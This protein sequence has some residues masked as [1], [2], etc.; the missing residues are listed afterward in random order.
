MIADNAI[1]GWFQG[2]TELGPRALGNRSILADPRRADN[3]DR[4]NARI[5]F[6]EEFR[7]FAP[8]VLAERAHEYFEGLGD[9]PFML[10]I[11]GVRPE[12]RSEIPAVVHVDGTARPQTVG[13]EGNPRYRALLEHFDKLTGVPVVLNTSFNV[14]GEPIVN[15]PVE[16]IRCF[17]ST[18]LDY[19]V[20]GN[21][22]L[23]KQELSASVLDLPGIVA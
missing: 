9:S 20:L 5:K 14:K 18:G 6:R 12:K 3:R 16:A 23:W 4:V 21:H 1:I 2:R 19:L 11:C 7:P 15:T 17:F 8:S 22:L 13:A 10:M